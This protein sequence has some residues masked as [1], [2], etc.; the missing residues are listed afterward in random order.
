MG[1]I[2]II[3][4]FVLPQGKWV[5][6]RVKSEHLYL[7]DEWWSIAR[8]HLAFLLTDA[9]SISGTSNS[10]STL[11]CTRCLHFP[12]F[13]TG[14]LAARRS[15]PLVQQTWWI[16]SSQKN[17]LPLGSISARLWHIFIYVAIA[18]YGKPPGRN[19]RRMF[20][21]IG[22]VAVVPLPR[23]SWLSSSSRRAHPF[24]DEGAEIQGLH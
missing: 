19:Q 14:S 23:H 17:H 1:I 8:F 11:K 18:A 21:A 7:A 6:K 22:E 10:H 16:T 12:P 20:S 13:F 2:N 4:M 24:V 3:A 5:I 9:N 15:G